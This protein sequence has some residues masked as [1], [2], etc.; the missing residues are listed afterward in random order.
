MQVVASRKRRRG[1]PAEEDLAAIRAVLKPTESLLASAP[2]RV[3]LCSSVDGGEAVAQ[4]QYTG[5]CGVLVFL[6]SRR[7]G[8]SPLFL[9]RLYGGC[10]ATTDL[11]CE[12][13]IPYDANY[14]APLQHFHILELERRWVGFSFAVDVDAENDGCD[15]ARAFSRKVNAQKPSKPDVENRSRSGTG[16]LGLF[17]GSKKRTEKKSKSPAPATQVIAAQHVAH[18]ALNADGT[19]D[20]SKIPKEW[21]AIFRAAGIRKKDLKDAAA[22]KIILNTMGET[23]L[24]RDPGPPPAP[25]PRAHDPGPPPTPP[26]RATPAPPSP[27]PPPRDPGPPPTPPKRATA[28]APAPTQGVP[29]IPVRRNDP[30]PPPR[31][32]EPVPKVP[33]RDRGPSL[34]GA[35][36]TH[37]P[38]SNVMP[39]TLPMLP[40]ADKMPLFPGNTTEALPAERIDGNHGEPS[41][42]VD[43]RA[44]PRVA[45]RA[46]PPS[47]TALEHTSP[48][49]PPSNQNANPLLAA[50]RGFDT[51]V[52]S[53]APE[54]RRDKPQVPSNPLMAAIRGFDTKKLSEAPAKVPSLTPLPLQGGGGT[55]ADMLRAR[56]AVVRRGVAEEDEEDE[57][58]DDDSDEWSD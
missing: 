14:T 32:V 4:W 12:F 58:D 1:K 20:L 10:N 15:A 39:K 8:G 3:F 56:M 29:P 38:T 47:Q 5:A 54:Q 45:S 46:L 35:A 9:L 40:S 42:E 37:A 34:P 33:A 23:L 36:P 49:A 48:T 25:P 44:S 7:G 24:A 28:A 51:K 11:L 52:L 27:P 18:V 57:D 43:V 26:K 22:T 13:E 16:F 41:Q 6:L 50:I 55:V 31:R 2:A 30:G 19:L 21:K 53:A 17:R